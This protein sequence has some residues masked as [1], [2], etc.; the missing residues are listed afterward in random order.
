MHGHMD[1]IIWHSYLYIL[2]GPISCRM[3]PSL[4]SVSFFYFD[5]K[6]VLLLNVHANHNIY[7][8]LKT[9]AVENRNFGIGDTEISAEPKA[10][11]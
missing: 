5:N 2:T 7:F 10:K 9:L 4:K 1:K 11:H 3:L 8:N 6:D